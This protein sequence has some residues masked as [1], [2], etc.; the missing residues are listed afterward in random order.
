MV[1]IIFR[2]A[3]QILIEMG[4][5]LRSEPHVPHSITHPRQT[6]QLSQD[7]RTGPGTVIAPG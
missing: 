4:R 5:A 6:S 3:G 2:E 1:L 7:V